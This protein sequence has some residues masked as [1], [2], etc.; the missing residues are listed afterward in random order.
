MALLLRQEVRLELSQ[1]LELK[2]ESILALKQE[3]S[4]AD[5]FITFEDIDDPELMASFI[6]FLTL[7]EVSHPLQTRGYLVLPNDDFDYRQ[8]PAQLVN[9]VRH[10]ASEVGIDRGAF[11]LAGRSKGVDLESVALSFASVI[12]DYITNANA[13]PNDATSE[14]SMLT[15]CEVVTKGLI[16]MVEED[17]RAPLED[18]LSRIQRYQSEFP[19]HGNHKAVQILYKT[20]FDE[21]RLNLDKK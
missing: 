11:Y 1:K 18:N 10:N 7:H 5:E 17:V 13:D 20:M 4:R 9:S 15:R 6:P 3:F 12:K 21:T 19:V 2:Q 8:L 14:Y 16:P